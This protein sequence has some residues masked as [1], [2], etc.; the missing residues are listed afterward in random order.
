MFFAYEVPLEKGTNKQTEMET[1][2]FCMTWCLQLDY[3]QVILEVDTNFWWIGS[4]VIITIHG[5]LFLKYK[6]CTTSSE[7]S[8][9]LNAYTL[10]GKSILQLT[11]S[12]NRFIRFLALF[13]HKIV[14][15]GNNNILS[16]RQSGN[17]KFQK[18]KTE[19][20]KRTSLKWHLVICTDVSIQCLVISSYVTTLYLYLIQLT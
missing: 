10:S 2:L 1:A 11:L 19:K 8:K 17:G 5:A 20:Y 15:K 4:R 16:T 18:N 3:N 13:Q 12:Q 14:T 6:G 9:N 7:K